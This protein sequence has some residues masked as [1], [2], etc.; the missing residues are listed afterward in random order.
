MLCAR[1]RYLFTPFLSAT[2][3]KMIWCRDTTPSP[4]TGPAL[5][6]CYSGARRW[7]YPTPTV[8]A[9]A[10]CHRT[11]DGLSRE[12]KKLSPSS[13]LRQPGGSER[14]GHHLNRLRFSRHSS[15]Q[16]SRLMDWED[17]CGLCA[18]WQ[19]GFTR[20]STAARRRVRRLHTDM[21]LGARIRDA[22]QDARSDNYPQT[23]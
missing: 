3:M 18:L 4:L 1:V 8:V 12:H 14:T 21:Y 5:L 11:M 7:V 2:L 10:H 16:A 9:A 13:A 20:L 17:L 22:Q 15:E 23:S 6:R 19:T